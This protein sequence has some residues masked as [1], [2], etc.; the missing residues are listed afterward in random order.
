[1]KKRILASIKESIDA[2]LESVRQGNHDSFDITIMKVQND[3]DSI[4]SKIQEILKKETLT[5][6][7][8]VEEI[9]EVKK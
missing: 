1:M 5:V 7:L 2:G 8:E 9:L 6:K 4:R 3:S